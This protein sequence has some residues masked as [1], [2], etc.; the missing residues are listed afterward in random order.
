MGTLTGV[1]QGITFVDPNTTVP[2]VQ[3]FYAGFTFQL[4]AKITTSVSYVG[5]Q[6]QSFWVSKNLDAITLAQRLQGGRPT[7]PI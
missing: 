3:Q 5:S 6:T 4:P 2:S 1:G 7:P